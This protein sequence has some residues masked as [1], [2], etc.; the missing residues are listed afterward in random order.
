MAQ[1]V[2]ARKVTLGLLETEFGLQVA[3]NPQFFTEWIAPETLVTD[4]ELQTLARVNQILN[5]SS[6]SRRCWK[7]RSRWWCFLH[8]LT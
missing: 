2:Q 1:A 4:P 6:K 8:S 7:K 3:T 5:I